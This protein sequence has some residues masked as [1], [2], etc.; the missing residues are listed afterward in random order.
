MAKNYSESKQIVPAAPQPTEVFREFDH[1]LHEMERR[2]DR[3][4]RGAF[5][6]DGLRYPLLQGLMLQP[7][8]DGRL[9]IQPFGHLQES[10]DRFTEGI[11]EPVLS[12]KVSEDGKSVDFR[13]EVPGLKKG[14]LD[15]QVHPSYV[16]IEG[17][18]E[19]KTGSTRYS[20]R[21][22][23]GF[24]LKTDEVDAKCEDGILTIHCKLAEPAGNNTRRVPVR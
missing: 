18:S 15:V 19:S 10:L 1:A 3:L 17:K 4:L 11:R 8:A 22:E 14:D 24:K 16:S 20:A 6:G 21:C 2:M 23:P 7:G 9:S 13:A 12:W 5:D